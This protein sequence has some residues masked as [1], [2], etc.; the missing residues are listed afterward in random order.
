M[1]KFET[2][3]KSKTSNNHLFTFTLTSTYLR[4]SIAPPLSFPHL[5][6]RIAPFFVHLLFVFSSSARAARTVHCSS[7]VRLLFVFCSS[8]VRL[9][10]VLCSSFVRLLFIR[11]CGS[12]LPVWLTPRTV[13]DWVLLVF[14]ALWY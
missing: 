11:L 14:L 3:T 4:F 2:L 1:Q 5:L 6:V 10:F 7:F 12:H 8:F 13:I 9:L